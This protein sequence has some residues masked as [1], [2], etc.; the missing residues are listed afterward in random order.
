M[1]KTWSKNIFCLRN[2]IF[3]HLAVSLASLLLFF[4]HL[5]YNT[6]RFNGYNVIAAICKRKQIEWLS[7]VCWQMLW[8]HKSEVRR[9]GL[10]CRL[11]GNKFLIDTYL[12]WS[13]K[14]NKAGVKNPINLKVFKWKV[15]FREIYVMWRSI[16]YIFYSRVQIYAKLLFLFVRWYE[17]YQNIRII[18]NIQKDLLS[19][20]I[21]R[22]PYLPPSMQY[23]IWQ[24]GYFTRTLCTFTF[25]TKS[26]I[27][28]VDNVCTFE[29]CWLKAS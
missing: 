24:N 17:K 27:I 28:K 3:Y 18:G 25:L 9:Y 6:V 15:S 13:Q 19:R 1:D 29:V 20:L 23:H 26:V 5:H 10:L 11:L 2:V 16:P 8:F 14:N 22:R 4:S 12:Q 21:A 7:V